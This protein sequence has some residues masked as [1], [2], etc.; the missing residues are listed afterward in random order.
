MV[1]YFRMTSEECGFISAIRIYQRA[2]VGIQPRVPVFLEAGFEK[3]VKKKVIIKQNLEKNFQIDNSQ[4][5]GLRLSEKKVIEI[6]KNQV[7]VKLFA[8]YLT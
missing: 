5:Y 1:R 7:Q 4:N 2:N 6:F 8:K 3:H